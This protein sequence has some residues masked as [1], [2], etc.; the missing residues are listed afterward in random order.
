MLTPQCVFDKSATEM[1]QAELPL[2]PENTKK[3]ESC[4][5]LLVCFY[6]VD[7]HQSSFSLFPMHRAKINKVNIESFSGDDFKIKTMFYFIYVSL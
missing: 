2:G 4:L 1:R 6:S 5:G 3:E 7:F